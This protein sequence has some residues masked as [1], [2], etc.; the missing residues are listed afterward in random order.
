MPV[1]GQTFRDWFVSSYMISNETL[2]HRNPVTGEPNPINLG[3]LDD[4][5]TLNG[6]TEEDSHYIADTGASPQS[7]I[8]QVAAY[9]ET[10]NE[11]TAATIAQ[12]GFYWQLLDGSAAQLNTGINNTTNPSSCLAHLRSVCVAAPSMWKRYSLYSIPSGGRGMTTQ[13]FTDW[14]S[15][16]LLTR[17]PYAMLGYTWAGCTNGQEA[18]P[19]AAEWDEDFG[20]PTGNCAEVGTSGVFQRD[21]TLATVAWDCNAQHGSITRK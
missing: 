8:D 2:L 18:W 3:W 6:P 1:N 9:R 7:M 14:S 5:M 19:R 16:F 20:S 12:G 21:W 11:L 15:E 17:G 10:M 4:S 13:G